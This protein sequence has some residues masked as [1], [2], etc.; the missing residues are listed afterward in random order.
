MHDSNQPLS[1]W[2]GRTSQVWALSSNRPLSLWT[3]CSNHAW[4]KPV[5]A[6][7]FITKQLPAV[8]NK[9]TALHTAQLSNQSRDYPSQGLTW[10]YSSP[11]P[12]CYP[13]PHFLWCWL[14]QS[15]RVYTTSVCLPLHL[16][17]PLQLPAS[18]SFLVPGCPP[19]SGRGGSW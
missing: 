11:F 7:K 8:L 9:R 15:Q 17:F 6:Q 4:G 13:A 5:D 16:Y 14:P 2:V 19:C 12:R 3:C 10:P 18:M 1:L